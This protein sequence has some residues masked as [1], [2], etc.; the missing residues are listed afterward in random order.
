MRR[1]LWALVVWGA[2]SAAVWNGFFDVLVNRGEKGYLLAQARA[3][4]GLGPRV[5]MGEVMAT[6]VEDAARVSTRW[7]VIVLA[8]GLVATGIT[9][10]R[11]R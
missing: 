2:L 6:T 7:A 3:E 5:T 11:P 9:A 8:A 10:R 4:L 1:W